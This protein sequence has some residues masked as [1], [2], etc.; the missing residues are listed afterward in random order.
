MTENMTAKG[1]NAKKGKAD[2]KP[3]KDSS[4]SRRILRLLLLGLLPLL[5]AGGMAYWM[6]GQDFKDSAAGQLKA[7]RDAKKSAVE[8]F[9]RNMSA[10]T[11]SMGNSA[12]TAK[13]LTGLKSALAGGGAKSQAYQAAAKAYGSQVSKSA[14]TFGLGQGFG[15][16]LIGPDGTVLFAS[17]EAKLAGQKGG[18][19]KAATHGKSRVTALFQ[20]GGRVLVAGPAGTGGVFVV[21]APERL[22]TSLLDKPAYLG[23][24]QA[25]FV[26]RAYLVGPDKRVYGPSALETARPK[27]IVADT[28]DIREALAGQSGYGPQ[29]D[30]AGRMVMSAYK[31]IKVVGKR[32]ALMV[33]VDAAAGLSPVKRLG[34]IFVTVGI[35]WA[36][37]MVLI[38]LLGTLSDRLPILA[39][40]WEFLRYRKKYWLLPIVLVLVLLGALIVLTQ[41]SAVAPF[42][43]ALF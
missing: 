39:E 17:D 13:A 38:G 21:R 2:N 32:W 22:L 35:V 5:I 8:S 34:R 16:Y 15:Y 18:P 20:A 33:S 28:P 29:K 12:L 41:G 25:R 4:L 40:F 3:A 30:Y 42:I 11:G 43:Y 7:Y 19:A 1:K 6:V 26:G 36:I 10:F 31:P 37:L 24:A 23:Q 9:F 27:A 14:A